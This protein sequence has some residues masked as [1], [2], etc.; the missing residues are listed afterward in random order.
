[1]SRSDDGG[2]FGKRGRDAMA[3]VG[4]NP[5]LVVAPLYVLHERV[6]VHR[7]PRGV[8]AFEAAH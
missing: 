7:H 2:E 3:W 4:F 5:E 1:M 6:A 8:V